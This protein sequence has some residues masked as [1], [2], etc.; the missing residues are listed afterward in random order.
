MTDILALVASDSKSPME[1]KLYLVACLA[2]M[3][4]VTPSSV[5]IWPLGTGKRKSEIRWIGTGWFEV[6]GPIAYSAGLSLEARIDRCHECGGPRLVV[7]AVDAPGRSSASFQKLWIKVLD[8]QK[9]NL[10]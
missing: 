8:G 3:R 10:A 4:K 1:G 6:G 7:M 5:E 2:S 9:A